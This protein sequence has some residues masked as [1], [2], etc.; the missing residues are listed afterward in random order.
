MQSYTDHHV[1]GAFSNLQG[2]LAVSWQQ[3]LL[4]LAFPG[5]CWKFRRLIVK[6]AVKS[7]RFLGKLGKFWRKTLFVL[8]EKVGLGKDIEFWHILGAL[9]NDPVLFL[10]HRQRLTNKPLSW[11]N[12]P[13]KK[14]VSFSK[15]FKVLMIIMIFGIP[16]DHLFQKNTSFESVSIATKFTLST[17]EKMTPAKTHGI[18]HGISTSKGHGIHRLV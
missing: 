10:N 14:I 9:E 5:Y 16:F 11:A 8:L 6:C 18:H 17:S 15:C 7:V 13:N 4:W 3:G 12:N 1:I 2:A